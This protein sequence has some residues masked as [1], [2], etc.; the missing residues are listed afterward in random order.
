MTATTTSGSAGRHGPLWGA[1]AG[2]WRLNEEQQV[3]T[4][5]EAIS[6]AGIAAGQ[7][8]LEVGCGTGVFLREAAHRGASVV[9]LDASTALIDVARERV[10]EAELHVGDM[11]FLPFEDDAFDAVAGFNAF[12]F[13]ADMVAA[14]REAGRVAKPGAPVVVQVWGAPER[15]DLTAMKRAAQGL[16]PP[17]EAD[18]PPEPGLWE[19]GVLESITAAAGLEPREAFDVRWSYAFDGEDALARAMLSPGLIVELVDV[20]GEAPVRAAILASLEPFRTPE[21]EYRLENEWHTLIA[22]A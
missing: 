2:D 6:R 4:Y 22:T 16:L 12:F 21:G 3:P 14:L 11:Q 18:A 8:V 15:C 20:V 5:A 19:P 7:R 1:R 17:A 13:A 10:P 9:G